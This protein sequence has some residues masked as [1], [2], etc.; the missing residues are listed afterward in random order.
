MP[1]FFPE[2]LAIR[3]WVLVTILVLV[4]LQVPSAPTAVCPSAGDTPLDAVD[5]ARLRSTP[6]GAVGFS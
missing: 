6:S 2:L 1:L 4:Q 5:T 3:M